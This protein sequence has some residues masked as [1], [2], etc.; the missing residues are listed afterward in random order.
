MSAT[1]IILLGPRN[2]GKTT[3]GLILSE[4]IGIE[5]IDLDN[6]I[7]NHSG[8]VKDIVATKG[9][10]VYRNAENEALRKV[11]NDYFN[12][13]IILSLGGG[14][15]AHEYDNLRKNNIRLINDFQPNEKILLLPYD[16]L[17]LNSRILTERIKSDM[18]SSKSKPPLTELTILEETLLILGTRD[19]F[20]RNIASYILYTK[21]MKENEVA[22][23]I[24]SLFGLFPK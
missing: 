13:D 17:K 19:K 11:V 7:T 14:T 6:I 12:R 8:T 18:N 20:Y 5:F 1:K 21:E 15:I 9:W 3:V 23:E 10:S 24:I 4:R 16:D 2:V 22:S